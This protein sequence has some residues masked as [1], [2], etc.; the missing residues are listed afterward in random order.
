MTECH[1][2]VTQQSAVREGSITDDTALLESKFIRKN[3]SEANGNS[4]DSTECPPFEL[5]PDVRIYMYCTCAPCGDGSMELCMAAQ[6]DA[7]P[8]EFQRQSDTEPGTAVDETKLL[9]GRAHFSLLGIVRRKPARTDAEST[10]SKSCSDKLALKQVSSLLT[11]QTS[12]LLAL[13]ENAYLAALILPEDEISRV[14]CDRAFGRN[15]RMAALVGQ[16]WPSSSCGG[17]S[18]EYRFRPFEVLSVPSEKIKAIWQ[19]AKPKPTHAAGDDD[20]AKGEATTR[21]S[22]P[23]NVSAVWTLAPS[24]ELMNPLLLDL[25]CKS[26]PSLCRS[27]T[28]LFESLIS[29]VKQGNK[30]SSPSARGASALSR[31]KMWSL[32]S[33][34]N[35][36]ANEACEQQTLIGSSVTSASPQRQLG[37]PIMYDDVKR[38][39][40]DET[41]PFS[42]RVQAI[43]YAKEVLRGWV[44]NTGDENWGLDV[45]ADTQ[46]RKRGLA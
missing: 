5:Q 40:K 38:A 20:K 3:I 13:T 19:F 33:K 15:G 25:G 22:K 46:K 2:L 37:E 23:G 8:W 43:R 12:R 4:G 21:K 39:G 27:K 29:G 17:N 34:I 24:L 9:D 30:A 11:W 10:R 28:G 36:I 45:L 42:A 32:F 7:T 18:V 1:A 35:T 31:A 6:E 44:P 16:S 14:A 26:L 41:A